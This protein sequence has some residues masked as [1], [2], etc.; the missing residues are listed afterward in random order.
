[1]P[2]KHAKAPN[3]LRLTRSLL[4]VLLFFQNFG[5]YYSFPLTLYNSPDGTCTINHRSFAQWK[6]FLSHL[7]HE[8]FQQK[9]KT[10]VASKVYLS[11]TLQNEIT[12]SH[13]NSA[14]SDKPKKLYMKD[15]MPLN[16]RDQRW[17]AR[18]DELIDFKGIHGHTNVSISN[19]LGV[20]VNNQRIQYKRFRTMH[21]FPV[22][23]LTPLRIA[24]LNRL[25][26]SWEGDGIR[27]PK[28]DNT[29]WE[30]YFKQLKE[31]I[32]VHGN[33][34][35]P[36]RYDTNPSLSNWVQRERRYYKMYCEGMP[37]PLTEEQVR[38]LQNVGFE[39]YS[40]KRGKRL[41]QNLF[42]EEW[43]EALLDYKKVYGNLFVPQKYINK[44][45]MKLGRWVNQQRNHFVQCKK[46]VN[47]SLTVKRII[48][49]N[50]IGFVWD[51]K[52]KHVLDSKF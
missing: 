16:E 42:W 2:Q 20:W 12:I 19:G 29:R 34:R 46:G 32:K 14:V 52:R 6:S 43:F 45:G 13:L 7:P 11:D 18:L 37:S 40:N 51:A 22:G 24:F 44:D 17:F 21:N 26:F 30:T 50:E 27:G 5:Y 31:F 10:R 3:A 48:A 39:F 1:M 35:V 33:S 38:K 15:G 4:K 9:I 41:S 25:G 28:R 49:L 23:G 36:S 47:T 8:T